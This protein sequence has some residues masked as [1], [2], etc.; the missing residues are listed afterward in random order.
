MPG[1]STIKLFLE[2]NRKQFIAGNAAEVEWVGVDK[3]GD[4]ILIKLKEV[5]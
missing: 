5:Q 3:T 4:V 1:E 2:E